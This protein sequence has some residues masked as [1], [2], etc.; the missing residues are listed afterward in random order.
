MT[1]YKATIN[2]KRGAQQFT[3]N[4]YSRLHTWQFDGGLEIPASSSPH[5]VPLPY[6]DPA[7]IDPEEAFIASLSSCHMLW[8]LAI[9]AKKN[10]CVDHYTD[11]AL[12]FMEK[13]VG[14]RMLIARVILR[15]KVLFSGENLPMD[16]VL[17]QMH[18]KAHEEC[19][20][21]NSVKTDVK[22]QPVIIT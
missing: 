9:A 14:G 5:V 21:A 17:M 11:E 6:S 3:D 16:A 18:E 19:F 15:P 2:W 20:I 22:C 10:F 1:E 4:R 8:F 12:G 13:N 7:A